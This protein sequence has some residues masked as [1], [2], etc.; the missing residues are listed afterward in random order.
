MGGEGMGGIWRIE[1][2]QPME[3]ERKWATR[4]AEEINQIFWRAREYQGGP[5]WDCLV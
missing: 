4:S 1:M 5:I 3:M 2:R